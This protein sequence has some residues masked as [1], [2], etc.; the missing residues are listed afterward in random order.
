MFKAQ[1]QL[2]SGREIIMVLETGCVGQLLVETRTCAVPIRYLPEER[3]N[4]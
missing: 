2:G 3:Q 4:D 1:D